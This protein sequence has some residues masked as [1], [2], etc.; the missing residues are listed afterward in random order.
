M[1]FRCKLLSL[2]SGRWGSWQDKTIE[3]KAN[4]A[5][6]LQNYCSIVPCK[7]PC[8]PGFGE[9][10]RTP[11]WWDSDVDETCNMLFISDFCLPVLTSQNVFQR[12][13]P[14]GSTAGSEAFCLFSARSCFAQIRKN[15]VSFTIKYQMK[16]FRVLNH[17]KTGF[18]WLIW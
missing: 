15:L 16:C 12:F 14:V 2:D 1:S 10:G 7:S 9:G 3:R 5:G 8:L 17:E 6:L 11:L 18:T 4:L 13:Q